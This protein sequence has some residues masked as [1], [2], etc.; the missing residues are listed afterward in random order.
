MPL[1][2]STDLVIAGLHD[3]VHA[4]NHP[5]ANSPLAP[6]TDSQVQALL[7]LTSLLTNIATPPRNNTPKTIDAPTVVPTD[8]PTLR[9]DSP[10]APSMRVEAMN[11]NHL[12]I[13]PTHAT[14]SCSDAPTNTRLTQMTEPTYDNST[15]AKGRC[16]CKQNSQHKQP[17]QTPLTLHSH[18]MHA[19]AKKFKNTII[20]KNANIAVHADAFHC[21]FHSNAINP[22]SGKNAEYLELSKSSDGAHWI[23]ACATE[24][25]C[26]C[27]GRGATSTM[28]MGTDTMFFIP[29]SKL[30]K[31]RKATY[32]H[33]V[34]ADRPKKAD[35][36][37]VRFTIGGNQVDYPGIVSTKTADLTTAKIL[38]NSILSTPNAKYMTA[39]LKDFYLGTPMEMYKYVQIPLAII[40]ESIMSEYNLAPLVHNGYIY[41]EVQKGMYG[42]P[43]AGHIAN[44]CLTKFLAPHG[45]APV[46][47][48]PSLCHK[49]QDIAFT[50][51]VDDFGVKYTNCKDGE[52][53]MTMLSTQYKVSEDWTGSHYCRLALDWDYK[54]R[55]CDISMPGYIECALQRFTH[56]MPTRPQHSPHAWQK[57]QYGAKTQYTTAPDTSPALD[58][59][60]TKCVQEIL[61]TLL[62]YAHTIDS[63]MLPTIGTIATQQSKGTMATMKAVTHLLNYCA[64]HPTAIICFIASDMVLHVESDASYLTAPKARS[65]AAGYLFLSSQPNDLNKPPAPNDPPPPGNGAIHVLCTIMRKVISSATEAE[66]AALFHNGKE[67][68]PIRTA[69]KELG[70]PQPP[71][72]IQTDNS[73]ASGIANDSIKQKCSKAIDMHF[74]WIRDPRA[75]GTVSHFLAQGQSE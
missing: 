11:K 66:L 51:V 68:C 20:A 61:G 12:G 64:T 24:I 25:G 55:T 36:R 31:G 57:P 67:A 65:R 50:L 10:A 56:P 59:S 13:D 23:E 37:H 26:L 15:G 62:Y 63:T 30:P 21:A 46:P 70:H 39:D 32:I 8:M 49:M 16:R 74:Y 34:C 6:S 28:T 33:I 27:Q 1:A 48:T 14:I 19:N 42:L 7:D 35:A 69:L 58:M 38:I 22:D 54:H 47:V 4:L 45:Y 43:Q 40:P 41:A 72:P 18:G 29:I 52:A 53:L 44:E 9:V 3:I 60:D 73:T 75:A 5:S 17:Q 71:T 2:S